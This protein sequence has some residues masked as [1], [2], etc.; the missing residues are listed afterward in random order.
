MG[1][2]NAHQRW[3]AKG[4]PPVFYLSLPLLALVEEKRVSKKNKK[5]EF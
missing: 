4:S 5:I 1:V 2:V 3:G